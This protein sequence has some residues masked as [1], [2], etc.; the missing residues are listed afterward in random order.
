MTLISSF[1]VFVRWLEAH[2]LTCPSVKWFHMQC[3]GCGMQRSAIALLKGDLAGSI[4][5][6]PALIPLSALVLYTAAHLIVRFAAGARVI[7]IL[8]IAVVAIM[9]MHYIYKI[10]TSQI[11]I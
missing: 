6:Y 3:M 10:F 4:A 8:Q 11:F 7:V 5:L 2:M 1:A 9:L